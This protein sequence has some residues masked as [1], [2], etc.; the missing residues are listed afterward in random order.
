MEF[1]LARGGALPNANRHS[2]MGLHP[3]K[4]AVHLRSRPATIC[5]AFCFNDLEVPLETARLNPVIAQSDRAEPRTFITNREGNRFSLPRAY[6][7]DKPTS[8]YSSFWIAYCWFFYHLAY[9][10]RI[11][12]FRPTEIKFSSLAE[13]VSSELERTFEDRLLRR[14]G[15]TSIEVWRPGA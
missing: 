1:C 3:G 12:A 13:S 8:K 7:S 15:R 6:W 5:R 4:E 10:F 14:L 11:V 2:K 9:G